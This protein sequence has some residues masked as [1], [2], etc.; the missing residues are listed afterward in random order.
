VGAVPDA[1][2]PNARGSGR[3][4]PPLIILVK[5]DGA[6]RESAMARDY[7]PL[8]A[9]AVAGLEQNTAETR[10]VLYDH[11]RKV[12][13]EQLRDLEPRLSMSARADEFIALDEAIRK[14]ESE[15]AAFRS[16]EAPSP[17]DRNGSG[18]A[19]A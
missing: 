13:G 19:G 17:D 8:I 12:L 7:Y 3:A 5:Q 6:E 11:A 10:Q 9:R 14:V 2:R 1:V 16:D 18:D 4:G 15:A